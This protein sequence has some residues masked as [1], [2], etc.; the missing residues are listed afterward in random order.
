MAPIQLC[1]TGLME[2]ILLALWSAQRV[3]HS[4]LVFSGRIYWLTETSERN[5]GEVEPGF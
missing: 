4:F 5:N 1:S 3:L 2:F